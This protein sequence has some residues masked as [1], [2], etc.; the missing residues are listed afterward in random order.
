M[1]NPI[2]EALLAGMLLIEFYALAGMDHVVFY[3]DLFADDNPM[4]VE[5][6]YHNANAAPTNTVSAGHPDNM[7]KPRKE[8]R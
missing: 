8:Y 3:P 5:R 2:A 7:P 6:Q 4:M 1:R